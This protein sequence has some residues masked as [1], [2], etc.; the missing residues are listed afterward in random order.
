M[1]LVEGIKSHEHHQHEA[2][3]NNYQ[4]A[5]FR[6]AL[7]ITIQKTQLVEGLRTR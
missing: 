4:G 6:N 5:D 7:E 1:A 3:E 2:E